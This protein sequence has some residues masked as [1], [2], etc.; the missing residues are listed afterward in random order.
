MTK[1]DNEFATTNLPRIR[2]EFAKVPDF[3][4]IRDEFAK[5]LQRIRAGS[6]EF[7]K[8]LK[9]ILLNSR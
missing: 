4:R 3:A 5:V 1:T 6:R 7:A 2:D 8:V 9:Q